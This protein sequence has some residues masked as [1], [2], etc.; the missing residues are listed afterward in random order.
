MNIWL[1]ALIVG[2]FLGVV[3]FLVSLVIMYA[4]EPNF[5]WE[6]YHFWKEV[7]FSYILTGIIAHLLFEYFG[8]NAW[9]C[10]YG[11]ACS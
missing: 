10:R 9:Y 2:I 3:G 11:N 7:V 8:I 5:K 6:K 4:T 1:E